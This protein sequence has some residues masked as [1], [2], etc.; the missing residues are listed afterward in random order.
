MHHM[1]SSQTP[2]N[3]MKANALGV[4]VKIYD[5]ISLPFEVNKNKTKTVAFV[6]Q[7]TLKIWMRRRHLSL[8]G[9]FKILSRLCVSPNQNF[10]LLHMKIIANEVK[11]CSF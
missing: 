5:D 7:V 8:I 6:I 1:S 4:P 10:D 3:D 2:A 9:L 11:T